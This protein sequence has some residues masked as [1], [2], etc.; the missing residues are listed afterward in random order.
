MGATWILAPNFEQIYAGWRRGGCSPKGGERPWGPSPQT[1]IS[2]IPYHYERPESL[3]TNPNHQMITCIHI[4]TLLFW[5]LKAFHHNGG[6]Q[7]FG[8]GPPKDLDSD[9]V[10]VV[11]PKDGRRLQSSIVTRAE[12]Q[13]WN[14]GICK[15]RRKQNKGH[16]KTEQGTK[17]NTKRN[18]T[19]QNKQKQNK[20]GKTQ[21]K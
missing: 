14:L 5:Y 16:N 10:K 8:A 17:Q 12:R 6:I 18:E 4:H 9:I 15:S 11:H 13:M 1:Y 3:Y 2:P 20:V 19:K 21:T 7:I